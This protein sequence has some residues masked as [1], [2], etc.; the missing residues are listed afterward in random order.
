MHS[1]II[2]I[3]G[4]MFTSGRGPNF[5]GPGTPTSEQIVLGY[6]A[7]YGGSG[8]RPICNDNY[9]SNNKSQVF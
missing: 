1:N 6:G 3:D 9:F 4:I 8:G 5:P 2:E 7:S